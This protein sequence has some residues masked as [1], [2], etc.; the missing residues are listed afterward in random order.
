MALP[1]PQALAVAAAV[2]AAASAVA[3]AWGYVAGWW[4]NI[5]MENGPFID[6]LPWFTY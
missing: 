6:G 1:R 4:F 3:A 5:A 2:A